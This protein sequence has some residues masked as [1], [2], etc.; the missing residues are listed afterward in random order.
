M[1]DKSARSKRLYVKKLDWKSKPGRKGKRGSNYKRKPKGWETKKN[2]PKK[3]S[4]LR[5]ELLREQP[6]RLTNSWRQMRIPL[7][8]SSP[9]IQKCRQL[10]LLR[11]QL[12]WKLRKPRHR[13]NQNKR[14]N[15][16]HAKSKKSISPRR[17]R[18][19]R[20]PV[21]PTL[22]QRWLKLSFKKWQLRLRRSQF[23]LLTKS[24]ILKKR[25][26]SK[27]RLKR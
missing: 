24:P 4:E 2:S 6:R 19:R 1:S 26:R 12:L 15:K 27:R 22:H 7:S 20:K 8:Q 10:Q 23:N 25:L 14:R 5:N 16:R 3:N 11:H 9:R 18:L 17:N 21:R 13:M